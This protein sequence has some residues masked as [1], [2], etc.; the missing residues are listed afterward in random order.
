MAYIESLRVF[1]R[2]L[3][4]GSITSGGRD[5]RLTPAVASK[6]IKELENKLGVRLF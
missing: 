6:R 3:E 4:L 2:V 1:I 5:L